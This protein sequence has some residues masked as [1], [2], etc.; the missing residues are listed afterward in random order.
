MYC[1]FKLDITTHEKDIF[2]LDEFGNYVFPISTPT[3]VV[4]GGGGA[5]G[6]VYMGA[7]TNCSCQPSADHLDGEMARRVSQVGLHVDNLTCIL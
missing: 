5:S 2:F 6:Q 3:S 1:H 4:G 7:S